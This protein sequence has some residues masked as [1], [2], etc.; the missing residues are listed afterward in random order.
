[1]ADSERTCRQARVYADPESA[2]PDWRGLRSGSEALG[3]R[4]F[5]MRVLADREYGD[6]DQPPKRTTGGQR[7][8][9]DAPYMYIVSGQPP[10]TI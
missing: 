3:T 7:Q 9:A 8:M 10:E 4:L 2:D 5:K 1:M 6:P